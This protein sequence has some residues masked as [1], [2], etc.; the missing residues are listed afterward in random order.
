MFVDEVWKLTAVSA[1]YEVSNFGRF[2]SL[3]R[4]VEVMNTYSKVLK[5]KIL[6]PF[7]SRKTGYLQIKIKGKKYSAH[8]LVAMGFCEGFSEGLVVNHKNGDRKDNRASNL[9]WVTSSENIKHAYRE[10][11]VIPEQLGKFGEENN[12]SKSVIATCKRTGKEIRYGAAMDAVREGFDSSSISRCCNG[13]S[14]SHKGFY[15][16]FEGGKYE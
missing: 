15:W 3:N 8:R 6:K 13:I 9:E 5:G 14:R 10:L 11:G 1:D 4:C 12:A 2:R 7:E 16:K